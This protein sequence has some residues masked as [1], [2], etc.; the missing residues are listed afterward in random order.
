MS[1]VKFGRRD[2]T[3]TYWGSPTADGSGGKSFDAPTTISVR[4]QDKSEW[5]TDEFGTQFLSN[6]EVY[7]EQDLD[8]GGYLYL[9]TS[10]AADPTGVEG[11]FLIRNFVS[12]PSY[13][14]NRSNRKAIL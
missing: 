9:G 2:Q 1:L 4:W 5:H 10:V 14:G 12:V 3:A 6:A 13:R 8:I 11:A 7:A